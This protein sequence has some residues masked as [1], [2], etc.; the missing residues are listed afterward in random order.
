[1][2]YLMLLIGLVTLVACGSKPD[3]APL[4]IGSEVDFTL[5]ENQYGK[6]FPFEEELELLIFADDME[7][8]SH[9]REAIQRVA[10]ECYEQGRLVFVA[11]ISGMPKMISQMVAV[12]KM[13]DYG[14]PIWLDYTGDATGGLPVKEAHISLIGIQAGAITTIKYVQGVEPVADAV[15]PLCGLKPEQVATVPAAEAQ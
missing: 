11:D 4:K 9:V 1:M 8:S 10:P 15:V 12:P 5:L 14:F 6:P 2:R 13:R 7:A 3:V